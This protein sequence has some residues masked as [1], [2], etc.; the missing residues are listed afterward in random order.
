[1][2]KIIEII[3]VVIGIILVFATLW[4]LQAWVVMVLWGAIAPIF[5]FSTISFWTAI[6]I[7]IAM[8]FIGGIIRGN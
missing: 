4:T 2:I 6:I 5:G 1:M 8:N 3:G 7:T